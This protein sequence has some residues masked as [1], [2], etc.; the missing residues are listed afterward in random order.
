MVVF[1]FRRLK[2]GKT[3][4][5]NVPKPLREDVKQMLLDNGYGYL[6]KEG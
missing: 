1:Y 5:S 2:D 4:L 3:T 6:I